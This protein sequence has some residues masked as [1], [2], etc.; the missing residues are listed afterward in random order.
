MSITVNKLPDPVAELCA[1]LAGIDG[2]EAVTIGGSRA[3]E[4]ADEG[5]DWDVGVYYRGGIDLAP[6]ERYGEV[7]PPGS[8]GRIMNG[9]AWLSLD[10]TKVDVLLRDLDVALYWAGQAQHGVYEVDALLGYIA[11]VPTYSLMAEL[12]L[13]RTVSG[14]PPAV[15]EYPHALSQAGARRWAQHADFSLT[16]ARMRAE[17]GDTVGTVGQVAKAAIERAHAVACRRRMWVLNEKKLIERTGLQD[18]HAR[19]VDVPGSPAQLVG[20]VDRARAA[21]NHARFFEA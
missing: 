14:Y 1:M 2:V 10:G 16:H 17:R 20:W 4:P 8:W 13:N 15:G 19:F 3:T 5:R 6:L 11:G 9:G 7:H 21:I 18:F 12:A